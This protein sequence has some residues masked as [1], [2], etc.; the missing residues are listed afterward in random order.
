VIDPATDP[1]TGLP[2]GLSVAAVARRLGV[3]PAT[4]RTWDRRYG[5]GPSEHTAG[6]HRRYSA[7]DIGR[8][9][10]MRALVFQGVSP[11]DAARIA[12]SSDPVE[13]HA[14][15]APNAAAAAPDAAPR[16]PRAVVAPASTEEVVDDVVHAGAGRAGGGRVVPIHGGSPKARG[17]ARAA[18]ALDAPAV[19]RIV[20]ES[21][22]ERGTVWTW[23][24]LLAPVL[25]GVGERF[26]STGQGVDLEHLLSESIVGALRDVA[27]SVPESKTSRPVLLASAPE[28]MHT[29]PLHAVAAALAER[30]IP[31]RML[32]ARL[33]VEA[34]V[35]AVRRSGPPAVMLWSHDDIT[36]DP[37]VLTAVPALRPAPCLVVGGPGW[38]MEL[39]PGVVRVSDL[40]DAVTR[41]SA[42]VRGLG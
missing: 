29:L 40:T 11:S 1:S 35:A 25:I 41:I 36:G 4:L 30:G 13:G 37:E 8:L 32:G 12:L 18:L 24:H 9:E 26:E 3:A 7:L 31:T 10:V 15:P 20:A 21:L 6:A 39:P 28:D 5:L 27:H 22:V 23:D 42:A 19:R 14:E 2:V 16:R 38:P 34:L 17:L 33:P